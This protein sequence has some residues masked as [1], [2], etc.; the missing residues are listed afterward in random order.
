MSYAKAE[1]EVS[2][3]EALKLAY[4]NEKGFWKFA[5]KSVVDKSKKMV[6]VSTSDLYDSWVFASAFEL[7]PKKALTPE[8]GTVALQVIDYISDEE[9]WGS[10]DD[11]Y[12][13]DAEPL[14][15]R[16]IKNGG[17]GSAWQ[18]GGPGTLV[19]SGSAA[20]YTAPGLVNKPTDVSVAVVLFNPDGRFKTEVLLFSNITVTP[21]KVEDAGITSGGKEVGH[22][23]IEGYFVAK[24]AQ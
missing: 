11:S 8:G 5:A 17:K 10:E 16:F 1:K 24:R 13:D 2:S 4:Q 20:T 22:L 21:N 3:T 19:G 18:L 23:P 7:I 6:A 9:L 14:E 15:V 12:M